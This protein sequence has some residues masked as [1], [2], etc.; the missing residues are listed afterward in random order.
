MLHFVQ[1]RRAGC[2]CCTLFEVVNLQ[3]PKFFPEK[4]CQHLGD[5]LMCLKLLGWGE[6]L[7]LPS[8]DCSCV[9][10][11]YKCIHFIHCQK[12]NQETCC[13]LSKVLKNCLWSHNTI[14]ILIH[15][16]TLGI[17]LAE[18]FFMSNTSWMMSPTHS[19]CISSLCYMFG[20]N[21]PIFQDYAMNGIHIFR[22]SDHKRSSWT[23]IF[24]VEISCLKSSDP[25]NWLVGKFFS[26]N[27]TDIP[28]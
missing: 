24:S 22:H 1:D 26:L 2:D 11:S 25:V 6:A 23:V 13:V 16:Q 8:S 19:Q 12:S 17:H 9:S 21:L 20:W 15:I 14:M 10:G 27:L 4:R 7:F 28:S 18:S 3:N 5:W